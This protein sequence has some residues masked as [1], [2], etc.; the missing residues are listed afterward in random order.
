MKP[1]LVFSM[2]SVLLCSESPAAGGQSQASANLP[3]L[4]NAITNSHGMRMVRVPAGAFQMG[5]EPF[6]PHGRFWDEQPVHD[7]TIS[8]DYWMGQEPVS[9][10]QYERFDPE[11]RSK[12]GTAQQTD[13]DDDPVVNVS[14]DEAVAFT[15]WL[16]EREGKPYRLPTEA[17]W[18][19]AAMKAGPFLKPLRIIKAG[20]GEMTMTKGDY[21]WEYDRIETGQ[22]DLRNMTG[23]VEQ[24]ALDW[25]GPYLDKP[26]TDPIGYATGDFRATRGRSYRKLHPDSTNYLRLQARMANVPGDRNLITGFRVVQAEM[27]TTPPVAQRPMP[28]W[29]RDVT[30]T[31]HHWS[32]TVDMDN[33]FFAEPREWI[34]LPQ[35]VGE[36]AGRGP[37]LFAE[38]HGPSL[39]YCPNGDLLAIFFTTGVTRE[40][41]GFRE[42]GREIAYLGT[43]LR[44]GASQW[45]VVDLFF[46]TPSRNDVHG[47]LWTA[48]GGTLCNW[49]CVSLEEDQPQDI[50]IQ[51]ESRDNGQTWSPARI[52]NAER[53]RNLPHAG[54][55]QMRSGRI[56]LANDAMGEPGQTFDGGGV[57]TAVHVSD[58]FGQTWTDLGRGRGS[59]PKKFAEGLTGPDIAGIHAA[60]AEYVNPQNPQDKYL[61]AFGR[62]DPINGKMPKSLSTDGG[63]NWTYHESPFPP[64][65][66]G[67][68]AQL[69]QLR[70][71]P[72][73]LL[74]FA[75]GGLPFTDADDQTFTG[76]GLYAA[77]SH[78]G[79]KTWPD[80][81][82]L[83]DGKVRT[84]NTR[85]IFGN[86]TMDGENAE[87]HG[88]LAAVQTPNR[89]IHLV[90]SGIHYRFNL[91]WLKEPNPGKAG[92]E[93][94]RKTKGGA[95]SKPYTGAE[96][97]QQGT[98][99]KP[100]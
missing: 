53:L 41:Y 36:K 1:I 74:S 62:V 69:I 8:R 30:Q 93:L 46:D 60:V 84:L 35:E 43:R 3:A 22:V 17:E 95:G 50:L 5:S 25:Y 10:A 78:D 59:G 39:T 7:V 75:N 19:Y 23:L 65:A 27:P 68:R 81:K 64:I 14:W 29:A 94:N 77:L 97:F 92:R 89:M 16:S 67:Q 61:V 85:C 28:R 37:W 82:L 87:P 44:R 66:G 99:S 2:L 96:P 73:L 47:V 76:R 24:W 56:V 54:A 55:F 51:R 48:S 79:G 86:V 71:G 42:V 15:K 70:E 52:I 90:S 72:L 6:C 13:G 57:G 31:P 12:R 58:D 33:P 11:H 18:E 98:D 45:D 40:V 34:R 49:Q 4:S 9:N 26:Q 88:Y 100:K 91:A 21:L 83:T 20:K 38:Q 80:R 63:S 32:P